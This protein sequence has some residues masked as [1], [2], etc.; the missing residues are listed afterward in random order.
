MKKAERSRSAFLKLYFAL[1]PVLENAVCHVL[2]FL[3]SRDECRDNEKDSAGK[4]DKAHDRDRPY[5][6]LCTV[7][8]SAAHKQRRRKKRRADLAHDIQHKILRVLADMMLYLE[9]R[10]ALKHQPQKVGGKRGY[11]DRFMCARVERPCIVDKLRLEVEILQHRM[12]DTRLKDGED[13]RL[14]REVGNKPLDRRK[15]PR[16]HR[17]LTRHS[18][19]VR[20]HYLRYVLEDL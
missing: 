17:K 2:L 7:H 13:I 19:T 3:L 11:L 16:Q 15:S 10:V 20:L 6:R 8:K 18:D 5:R 4:A 9:I 12:L 1:S 14:R